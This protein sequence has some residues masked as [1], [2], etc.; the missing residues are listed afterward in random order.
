M[1]AWTWTH[2]AHPYRLYVEP[3]YD[4]DSSAIQFFFSYFDLLKLIQCDSAQ[5]EEVE[6][7]K[8][9]NKNKNTILI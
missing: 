9:T 7:K 1:D 8:T 2:T 3:I 4:S 6:K 5:E